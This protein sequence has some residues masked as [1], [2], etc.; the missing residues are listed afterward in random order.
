MPVAKRLP[1]Y[2]TAPALI[3]LLAC[4]TFPDV[5]PAD[6]SDEV[7]TGAQTEMPAPADVHDE[8]IDQGYLA[9][10]GPV[11]TTRRRTAL[12]GGFAS[13]QVNVDGAGMN[14]VGDAANEPSIALDPTHP[15]RMAIG[16]RQFDTIASNFRQ[17]GLGRTTDGGTT[18]T[19]TVLTPGTFRSDPVLDSN[20]D[21]TFHYHSLRGTL[22]IDVFTSTDAGA[23]WGN[24]VFAFGG[25]KAWAAVD[26]SGGPGAG[27]FY[28]AW[29]PLF[30]CCDD[31]NFNRSTDG[32]ASFEAPVAIS[33][34][35]MWGT[36]AVSPTGEVYVVGRRVDNASLFAVAKSTSLEDSELPMAFDFV[37]PLDLGG[38][39]GASTGPNPGGLLGQAWIAPARGLGTLSRVYALASVNPPGSDPLD[40]HF[41]VSTDGGQTWGTPRRLNDDPPGAWQWFGTLS[42]AP[43]GRLDVVWNDTRRDPGGFDSELYYTASF[44]GGETWS[45]PT[46]VSPAFDPH[47]GW[48]QQNKIGDYYDMVSTFDAAHVAYS[49]TFND[50]QDVYYLR[51]EVDDFVFSDGFESGDS[52]RWSASQP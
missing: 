17:A 32:G 33:E 21:G 42:V 14:I 29:S 28:A 45:V 19:A 5:S 46:P 49:A 37:V 38:S 44:D 41:A 47:L 52:A 48:P 39:M 11:R 6:S 7:T 36:V 18:W 8:R 43:D 25:D 26:R 13:I 50:E 30:G 27:H 40:V 2:T 34:Q 9:P 35:I 12:R 16:W 20:A 31:D 22:D 10:A 51:I 4:M 3:A 15:D 23:T 1:F 24:P